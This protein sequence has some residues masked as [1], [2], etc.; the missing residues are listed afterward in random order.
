MTDGEDKVSNVIPGF[1]NL[2]FIVLLLFFHYD[3]HDF[4]NEFSHKPFKSLY[5]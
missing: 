2:H 4:I 1:F 3:L 5:K